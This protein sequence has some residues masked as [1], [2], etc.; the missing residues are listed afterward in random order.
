MMFL[1]RMRPAIGLNLRNLLEPS[2]A[3]CND[4][5]AKQTCQD[6]SFTTSATL[7]A[8][9]PKKRKRLDPAVLRARTERKI[10]KIEK[11]MGKLMAQPKQLIPILEY[12]LDNKQKRELSARPSRNM[13]DLGVS[14]SA[15]LGARRLWSFYRS[16]QANME[17]KSLRNV[18]RAQA[19]ALQELH[20]LDQDLYDRTLSVDSFDLIP[21]TSDIIRKDT[22]PNGQ[23]VAP[24]G[25][26]SN[27]SKEWIM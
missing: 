20:K 4:Q 22:G 23:Y 12:E 10:I 27:I 2:Q 1:N 13:T 18:I 11:E 26:I 5:L 16:I 19:H 6:R 9:P 21:Y 15:L 7:N 17:Q 3:L 24:D 8:Q 25:I 14:N